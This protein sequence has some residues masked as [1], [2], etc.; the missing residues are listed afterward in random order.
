MIVK[1]LEKEVEHLYRKG[2]RDLFDTPPTFEKLPQLFYM[3]E[4]YRHISN[5]SDRAEEAANVFGMVV[6]KLS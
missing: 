6:M 1:S 3:R 5:M 4:V 2:I